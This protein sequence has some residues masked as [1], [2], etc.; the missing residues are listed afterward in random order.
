MNILSQK[1][2]KTPLLGGLHCILN[3]ITA[4]PYIQKNGMNYI[5]SEGVLDAVKCR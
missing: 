1:L 2:T 4:R 3:D 5:D